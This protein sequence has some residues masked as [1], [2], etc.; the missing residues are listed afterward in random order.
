MKKWCRLINWYFDHSSYRSGISTSAFYAL[1]FFLI[2]K[3]T[4]T[5]KATPTIA[6]TT[7]PTIVPTSIGLDPFSI[8]KF[9]TALL[10]IVDTFYDTDL[11]PGKLAV[12]VTNPELS[13]AIC[14]R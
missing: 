7:T 12:T 13:T 14:G 2:K 11:Y 5:I 4:P 10:V 9:T 6:P 8:K 1:V 3:I